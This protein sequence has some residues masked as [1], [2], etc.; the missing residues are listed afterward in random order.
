MSTMLI[1][2]KRFIRPDYPR[3][4]WIKFAVDNAPDP[5]PSPTMGQTPKRQMA[6]QTRDRPDFKR[7]EWIRY[8]VVT[9]PPPTWD[10]TMGQT[11]PP[12]V[13][14]IE[15]TR[16]NYP[17]TEWI[18]TAVDAAAPPPPP[19]D[20][21]IGGQVVMGEM[22][23][24]R[25]QALDMHQ[26]RNVSVPLI[27][28]IIF[29]PQ[30][31]VPVAI[32]SEMTRH[33]PQQTIVEPFTLGKTPAVPTP[34]PWMD[35]PLREPLHMLFVPRAAIRRWWLLWNCPEV[36]W[37]AMRGL[38]EAPY[39]PALT[40]ASDSQRY[41][42][43]PWARRMAIPAGEPMI[44][45][46]RP[47]L[48]VSQS[49]PAIRQLQD[50]SVRTP[51]AP[52]GR[53][54]PW[55]AYRAE[56]PFSRF[57]GFEAAMA[58]RVHLLT[59]PA[60]SRRQMVWVTYRATPPWT[61]FADFIAYR[62][63][64]FFGMSLRTTDFIMPVR[65]V[66]FTMPVRAVEFT[67]PVKVFEFTMPLLGSTAMPDTLQ[68][69]P[70]E[71]L[72]ASYAMTLNIPANAT[73][74]SGIVHLS[75]KATG[76]VTD[77]STTLSSGASVNAGT[78]SLVDDPQVGAYLKIN[79]G[80]ANEEIVL[81]TAVSAGPSPFTVTIT[82]PLSYAHNSAEVVL[83]EPGISAQMMQSTTATVSAGK[84][85]FRVKR[86]VFGRIYRMLLIGTTDT[87][88]V[89]RGELNVAVDEDS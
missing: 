42:P 45:P 5:I 30:Y 35:Q 25:K 44:A 33:R 69:N 77:L 6:E 85:L 38:P 3:T 65:P 21:T 57:E 60:K 48:P 39:N 29:D 41:L 75:R 84:L 52:T 49:V 37:I 20:P 51:P 78:I 28:M 88:I 62:P 18:K 19:F 26:F 43:R 15:R 36:D 72:D 24:R 71:E 68:K 22:T 80:A 76:S 31:T 70:I 32:M 63:Q 10:P 87:G 27:P 12:R 16:P 14:E 61:W 81:A 83:Y 66:D 2:T 58:Q 40:A 79:I 73:L 13:S 4:D 53:H 8:A 67:M 86:G 46:I 54:H 17:R 56:P 1:T 11:P 89:L 47:S 23:P 74:A 7:E 9:A 50:L 82:P 34:I 64:F 55:M 59:T